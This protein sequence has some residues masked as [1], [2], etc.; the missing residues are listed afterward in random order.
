MSRNSGHCP[1]LPPPHSSRE[2][3]GRKDE[4]TE[5]GHFILPAMSLEEVRDQ[6]TMLGSKQGAERRVGLRTCT[7][8]EG[9]TL[10]LLPGKPHSEVPAR[11]TH[12]LGPIFPPARIPWAT[13]GTLQSLQLGV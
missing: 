11:H 5:A 13:D 8:P 9:L 2:H 3:L 12:H 4:R 7:R 1:P 6:T 10:A